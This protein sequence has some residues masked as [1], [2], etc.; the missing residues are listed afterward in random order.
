MAITNLSQYYSS[1]GQ[2]LPTVSDR[3]SVATKAGISNYTGTAEQNNQLL[4][5]L[6]KG[7]QNTGGGTTGATGGTSVTNTGTSVIP[8]GATGTAQV[9]GA[10]TYSPQK[11]TTPVLTADQAMTDY[12]N[13]YN[14]WLQLTQDVANQ[15]DAVSKAQAQAKADAAQKALNDA[16]MSLNQ[17]QIDLQKQKQQTDADVAKAKLAALQTP[18][19]VGIGATPPSAAPSQPSPTDMNAVIAQ[20]TQQ[21]GSS[22]S[23]IQA[24]RDQN[25]QW[26]NSKINQIMTGTFPLSATEQALMGSI[27]NAYN[28]IVQA[29]TTANQSLVNAQ[30]EEQARTGGEYAPGVASTQL[31]ATITAGTNRIASLDNEAAG[32]MA[33]LQQSFMQKDYQMITAQYDALDKALTDKSNAIKDLFTAVTGAEK[34]QRDYELNVQKFNEQKS[35]DAFDRAYKTE[36]IQIKRAN[37]ILGLDENGNQVRQVVG[38]NG[39]GSPIKE[40]Q[41]AFLQKLPPATATM[42][43]SLTDYSMDPSNL[44]SR[45]GQRQ[46]ILAL[47]HQYDPSYN[48]SNYK[49]ISALRKD[50][51]SGATAKNIASFNTSINHLNDLADNFKNL[52][53]TDITKYNTIAD[54]AKSNLGSGDITKVV[55]DLNAVTGELA[56]TFKGMGATDQEI[57]NL[58]KGISI[59]SSPEQFKSFIEEATRLLGGRI[60]ALNSTYENAA[61]KPFERDFLNPTT[62]TVLSGL[63]NDGYDI[64]VPGVLYTDPA[65]YVKYD[66]SGA[67]NLK[68]V[69]STY[70]NLSQA[71]ALQLAQSL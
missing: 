26:F 60:T 36:D 37:S 53:N 70:P 22:V 69:I 64:Q 35:Q 1:L 33:Q 52:P 4:N 46:Q 54:W 38:T 59:N 47:A 5:Y 9:S 67:A 21:F 19:M 6:Q 40:D 55:T 12:T 2:S 41:Q 17:Q 11:S 44:S 50:Y 10:N 25:T 49:M 18:T 43:K 58:E 56:K 14:A 65:S 61:G 23:D 51:T 27:Q 62:K 15:K 7:S 66:P 13:K 32:V 20:Q 16:T 29:Q 42:V 3:S 24:Q 28:N 30:M 71:D 39:D 45:S 48:E 57:S 68:R 8:T 63:K 34:D 31:G